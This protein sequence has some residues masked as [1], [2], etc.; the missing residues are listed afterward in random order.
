MKKETAQSIGRR[1]WRVEEFSSRASAKTRFGNAILGGRK[2]MLLFGP[3]PAYTSSRKRSCSVN[4]K[5]PKNIFLAES[6]KDM[7][8]TAKVL[9]SSLEIDCYLPRHSAV[10]ATDSL[11]RDN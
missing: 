3:P 10:S 2:A 9:R 1:R 5:P 8:K 6:F 7:K 4:M 11:L